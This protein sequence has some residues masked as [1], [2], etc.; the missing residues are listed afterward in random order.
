MFVDD[1]VILAVLHTLRAR[2]LE[3]FLVAR[4]RFGSTPGA[5]KRTECVDS[6]TWVWGAIA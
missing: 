2:H 4:H 1:K 6:A 3:R 5:A